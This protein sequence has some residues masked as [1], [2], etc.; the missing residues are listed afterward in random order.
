MMFPTVIDASMRESFSACPRKFWWQYM[1]N[2]ARSEVNI[3]LLAGGAFA[4]AMEVTRKAF[5]LEGKLADEA[6][7]LGAIAL[8]KAFED[9]DMEEVSNK[10][11]LGMLGALDHYFAV[12]PL[13]S[14]MVKPYKG[15]IECSFA[16]PIP[17]VKHP[18][19][20]EPILYAGRFDMLGQMGDQLFVVD[21]KTTAA[22]GF[23]WSRQW[24]LRG[25]IIGYMWAANQMG[26]K[27][28]GALIRGIS[29]LKR[30]YGNAQAIIYRQPWLEEEWL[31]QLQRDVFRMMDCFE[32]GYWDKSFGSACSS[33]GGCPY[34]TLCTSADPERWIEG[35][36]VSH[37]WNPLTHK[38]EPKNEPLA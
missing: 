33:Y 18:Q 19:T 7:G 31:A 4:K 22:L 30:S 20:G 15:S 17:D 27:V 24:E 10:S 28:D 21:E 2:L 25:Q 36:Y 26:W 16:L 5:W 38:E 12:Y 13:A 34:M 8:V 29:I 1:R 35:N 14:D 37:I 32:E 6:L 3:H 9:Y 23:A 11:C